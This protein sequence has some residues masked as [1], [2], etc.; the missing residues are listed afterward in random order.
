MSP[1]VERATLGY[2]NSGVLR[3]W[4]VKGYIQA[5]PKAKLSGGPRTFS[6][7]EVVKVSLMAELRQTGIWLATA[8]VLAELI[9]QTV[10]DWGMN[11]FEHSMGRS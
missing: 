11:Q 8:A 2:V 3:Q 7:R 10:D 1:E 9:I 6:Y 5:G 4:I